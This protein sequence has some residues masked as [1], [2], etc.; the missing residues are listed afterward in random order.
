MRVKLNPNNFFLTNMDT[1]WMVIAGI[2]ITFIL[3]YSYILRHPRNWVSS[4]CEATKEFTN[5]CMCMGFWVGFL[6]KFSSILIT[7]GINSL[8]DVYVCFLLGCIVSITSF[9]GDVLL[10]VMDAYI[11]DKKKED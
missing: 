5:C 7:N 9:F 3:K 8:Q 11:D 1:I 6:L 2:G 4:L 10:E